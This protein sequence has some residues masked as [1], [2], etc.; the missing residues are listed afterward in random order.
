MTDMAAGA[1]AARQM[2]QNVI[3][4]QYDQ[5]TA[6][7]AAEETQLK[8]QGDRLKSL[9]A[10][11]QAAAEAEAEQMRLGK[12][13][14]ARTMEE[15]QYKSDTETDGR[16]K[17]WLTTEDGKKA[18]DIEKLRKAAV[19]KMEG[20]RVKEGAE[21]LDQAEK[22]ETKEI[23]NQT[24]KLALSNEAVA[25][26]F[27]AVDALDPNDMPKFNA[28]V[29]RFP[30]E[31]T[32]A[33][34]DQVG[35]ENWKAYN[36]QEK[37]EVLSR[38]F[39]NGKGLLAEQLKAVE[40]EKT[41]ALTT[42]REAVQKEIS[43]SAKNVAE[44]KATSTE[45]VADTKADASRDVA[46]QKGIDDLAKV[47]QQGE[48]ALT[49]EKQRGAD[50]LERQKQKDADAM[51]RLKEENASKE[52]IQAHE[53]ASKE[54]IRKMEDEAKIKIEGMR[55][56]TLKD[57]ADAKAT[58][59]DKTKPVDEIKTIDQ[60]F[61]RHDAIVKEGKKEEDALI[62]QV[63]DADAILQKAKTA[64]W[65]NISA[66]NQNK[67]TDAYTGA[68]TKLNAFRKTLAQKELDSLTDMPDFDKKASIIK[69]LQDQILMFDS[70]LPAP[71]AVPSKTAPASAAPAAVAAP[72]ATTPAAGASAAGKIGN[73]S[74]PSNAKTHDGY[75]ARQNADGSYSTEVSITVTN[76]K[77]NGGKPTNIPSLWK[78]KEVDENTAVENALAS[79]KKYDSFSTIPEAVD[80]AIK[81]SKAGGAGG[82]SNK[83]TVEQQT[84]FDAAKKANP[85]MSDA[86]I[87]AEG[88]KRKKL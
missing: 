32:K 49:K 28:F 10:P 37:K 82:T 43:N 42:S 13:R 16:L 62:K 73:A 14:L 45:K 39:L 85:T 27:V 50:A 66:P 57:I 25:K 53:D 4:A 20:N 36:P 54:R 38:L 11:Q 59:K 69:R 40:L 2:Q 72:A 65:F 87:I 3:G 30:V 46:V 34:T 6:A 44:I 58:A 21:L 35:V 56:K 64:S 55:D 79:G 71:A 52:R 74:V 31:V 1:Q 81:R 75:P 67:A 76:P 61:K 88:K 68:V 8:L 23:A 24:K 77:L 9:Y 7:A 22:Q 12:M 70:G 80:A 17:T 83:F 86:D 51:S 29:D 41:K 15:A 60:Y 33:I 48:D 84:W 18:T 26:A 78:G 63:S 19:F 47:K 5:A